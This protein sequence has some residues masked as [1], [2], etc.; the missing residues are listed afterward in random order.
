MASGRDAMVATVDIV[1]GT[2]QAKLHTKDLSSGSS[3]CVLFGSHLLTPCKFQCLIGKASARNWKMTIWYLDLP[4]SCFLE[5]YTD[6]DGKRCCRFMDSTS[7]SSISPN[8]SQPT[9]MNRPRQTHNPL[10]P[11][12]PP[13]DLV[14]S[15]A[16]SQPV[17]S[18]S[19]SLNDQPAQ[20]FLTMT[21]CLQQTCHHPSC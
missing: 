7:V 14:H 20:K 10:A 4:L 1:C 18:D 21:L 2:L 12:A 8:V 11:L 13:G 19:S 6:A 9:S 5:S 16:H 3:L 15:L 17:V